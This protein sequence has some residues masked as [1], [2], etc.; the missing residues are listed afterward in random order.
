[1]KTLL[2]GYG[3]ALREDDGFGVFVARA[4]KK[5][6]RYECIEIFQLA[7]EL[8]EAIARFKKVVFIDANAEVP[9]GT[10]AVPLPRQSDVLA[11]SLTP[12]SLIETSRKYYDA[13]MDYLIFSVGGGSFGY[14][15]NL[16]PPLKEAAAKLIAYLKTI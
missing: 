2:I 11:H 16:T 5:T 14:R 10:F 12:W 13:K 15:E 4:L 9:A 8:A 6:R 3:N 1:L 7:P